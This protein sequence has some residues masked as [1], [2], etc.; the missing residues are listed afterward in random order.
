MNISIIILS[1]I[2]CA[3]MSGLLRTALTLTLSLGMSDSDSSF[4]ARFFNLLIGFE[5]FIDLM[6]VCLI[7]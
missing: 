3:S 1:F 5:A 6:L 2:I 4:M 7:P